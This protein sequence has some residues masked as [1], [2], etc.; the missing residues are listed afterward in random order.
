MSSDSKILSFLKTW[1]EVGYYVL[2][3]KR[4]PEDAKETLQKI[5]NT[6]EKEPDLEQ[7][8]RDILERLEFAIRRGTIQ[9]QYHEDLHQLIFHIQS[10]VI[11]SVSLES[12]DKPYYIARSVS[13]LVIDSPVKHVIALSSKYKE[14][15]YR[16]F[17]DCWREKREQKMKLLKQRFEILPS[18]SHGG[19]H[20]TA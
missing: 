14:F 10:G 17:E 9:P 15:F 5:I 3:G 13:T 12:S 2:Q 1:F 7:W 20:D 16:I 6:S 19:C 8:E 18:V 11:C 4:N